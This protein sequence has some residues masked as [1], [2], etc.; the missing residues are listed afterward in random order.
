MASVLFGNTIDMLT[1]ATP[2]S[3]YIVA[4]DLDGVLKQK[5]EFGVI[6]EIGGG[7]INIS[8]TGSVNFIPKWDSTYGLS[9]TS[10]IYDD[11]NEVV[12][13]APIIP[14][15]DDVYD[16]GSSSSRWKDIYIGSKIDFIENVEFIHDSGETKMIVGTTSILIKNDT[17]LL[18]EGA[19]ESL[20]TTIPSFN[21]VNWI[22]Y[23]DNKIYVSDGNQF[24]YVYDVNLSLQT[25][26]SMTTSWYPNWRFG[27]L[28]FDGSRLYVS[29]ETS[30]NGGEGLLAYI[31]VLTD[32]ISYSFL[33]SPFGT[34]WNVDGWTDLSDYETREYRSFLKVANDFGYFNNITG[35]EL[36][37]K[38]DI[39]NKYYKLIFDSWTGGANGGGFSYSRAE[40]TGTNS[41]G[42]TVSFIKT[43]YGNEVDIIDNN[44]QITRNNRYA[45][46]NLAFEYNIGS[47]PQWNSYDYEVSVYNPVDSKI[48]AYDY[49]QNNIVVLDSELRF[50]DLYDI[51]SS[52]PAGTL[53]NT[54]YI[55]TSS[56]FSDLS[57][58]QTRKYRSFKRSLDGASPKGGSNNWYINIVGTEMVMHDT[59][60][61]KYYK[62][63]F[64]YWNNSS[65]GGFSYSRAEILGPTLFGPTVSF[66]R[67]DSGSEVDV[68]DTGLEISRDNNNDPFYNSATESS[69]IDFF[70]SNIAVNT[71]NGDIYVSGSDINT[72]YSGKGVVSIYATNSLLVKE[73]YGLSFSDIGQ[74][75]NPPKIAYNP[76]NNSMYIGSSVNIYI[77]DGTTREISA[78]LDIA[79]YSNG[80]QISSI[81]NYEDEIIVSVD[82]SILSIDTSNNITLD[83]TVSS[84]STPTLTYATKVEDIYLYGDTSDNL[85][86]DKFVNFTNQISAP[87]AS[88][89]NIHTLQDKSGTLAHLD[90]IPEVLTGKTVWVDATYGNNTTAEPY[91]FDLPYATINAATN[92]ALSGD[93]VYIRPGTY[94]E[95]VTLKDGV[96][97]W[98]D[99]GVTVNRIYYHNTNDFYEG[100]TSSFLGHAKIVATNTN[101]IGLRGG[102]NIVVR[103]KSISATGSQIEVIRL[104]VNSPNNSISLPTRY[105]IEVE[106]DILVNTTTG[107]VFTFRSD[108][109][110]PGNENPWKVK[111]G[112]R[113]EGKIFAGYGSFGAVNMIFDGDF[114]I[115]STDGWGVFPGNN[116][117]WVYTGNITNLQTH[118]SANSGGIESLISCSS[119]EL[120]FSGNLIS[121][122]VSCV[123][124]YTPGRIK[125]IN[126]NI[127]AE[128]TPP[129]KITNGWDNGGRT[130]IENSIIKDGPGNT[131]SAVISM[132]NSG[133]NATLIIK[134]SFIIKDD[135][136]SP[137]G[138]VIYK[139]NT[140]GVSII[141]STII[142]GASQNITE[143]DSITNG[144]FYFKGTDSNKELGI[145]TI[146]VGADLY[147]NNTK[148]NYID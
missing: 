48:Y 45:I 27:S 131:Q 138:S 147:E 33:G 126:S 95:T 35:Q 116:S 10:S 56:G 8:G 134:D 78:I 31:D 128:N 111:W 100:I 39:N 58:Y 47:Y 57:D 3:G 15:A 72:P 110:I 23:V 74:Y 121:N 54:P 82:E 7:P 101:A 12:F 29:I 103:V 59:I 79:T 37:M 115:T 132:E 5:D 11:G 43:D 108:D 119:G 16:I 99:L 9:S 104:H 105:N 13:S 32:I 87:T 6:T 112:G 44:I 76:I 139:E 63:I 130:I 40:I 55:G 60:N 1:V 30:G 123:D 71:N 49:S 141:N 125:I 67:T 146:N 77:I 69:Y 83:K 25:T 102:L 129:L 91:R 53:W 81:V 2:S 106:D 98:A 85:T 148:I 135:T 97:F 94:S 73:I 66:I 19:D 17:H 24:I 143:T 92:A 109:S 64:D 114:F 51:T 75:A 96:N 89:N 142:C 127:Y 38:D 113:M 70:G 120:I 90:D 42:T 21:S 88:S 86:Y 20:T 41:I 50:L 122:N 36:I 137:T 145:N 84:N 34:L 107:R 26:I 4:Y 140:S 22:E 14:G 93:L 62:F 28:S 46:Y 18:L 118:T 117:K 61:D 133:R 65:T 136:L 144:E 52:S 68:I 80:T 124:Y